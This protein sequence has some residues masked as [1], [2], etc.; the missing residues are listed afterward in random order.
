MTD[1][2]YYAW[3]N[4]ADK[5]QDSKAHW[6]AAKSHEHYC[7]RSTRNCT[8]CPEWQTCICEEARAYTWYLDA[9]SDM[10]NGCAVKE[11]M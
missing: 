7:K 3:R 10:R 9:I 8:F 6:P 5:W 11:A 2:A 4:D 1:T